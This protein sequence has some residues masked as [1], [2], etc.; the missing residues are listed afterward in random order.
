MSTKLLNSPGS[1]IPVW[2]STG[3]LGL[4]PQVW[5]G[6][7]STYITTVISFVFLLFSTVTLF[8][9]A[10]RLDSEPSDGPFGAGI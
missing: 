5:L 3:Q 6:Y 2:T 10:N 8:S 4:S 1:Q 9:V 7:G